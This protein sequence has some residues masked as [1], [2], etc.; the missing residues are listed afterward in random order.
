MIL[1]IE[2]P[3]V[4][5]TAVVRFYYSLLLAVSRGKLLFTIHEMTVLPDATVSYFLFCCF[6]TGKITNCKLK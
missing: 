5:V 6:P 2:K 4:S 3:K 1:A